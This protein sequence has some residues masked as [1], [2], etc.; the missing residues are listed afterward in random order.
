MTGTAPARA[1]AP[2]SAAAAPHMTAAAVGA[3]ALQPPA[4]A[5]V[6][7]AAAAGATRPGSAHTGS[8][9][10]SVQIQ[11]PPAATAEP[12]NPLSPSSYTHFVQ[13]PVVVEVVDHQG[14]LH[15]NY[16]I[17]YKLPVKAVGMDKESGE[18]GSYWV[19]VQADHLD[20]GWVRFWVQLKALTELQVRVVGLVD[21]LALSSLSFDSVHSDVQ[22]SC[23]PYSLL[24]CSKCARQ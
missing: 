4:A 15:P 19:K 1:A 5:G 18:E 6:A 22:W 23:Q 17:D 16:V 11:S 10:N 12:R 2:S 24:L 20:G 8:Y 7:A 3:A 9:T 14:R 13:K 21:I